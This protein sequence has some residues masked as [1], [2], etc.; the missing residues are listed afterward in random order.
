[1]PFWLSTH[2]AI[3]VS[4]KEFCSMLDSVSVDTTHFA[5]IPSVL[6]RTSAL[7]CSD[8]ELEEYDIDQILTVIWFYPSTLNVLINTF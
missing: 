2:P 1:M 8:V 7:L 4:H 3:S 6:K 5:S